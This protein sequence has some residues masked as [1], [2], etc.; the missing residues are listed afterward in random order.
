MA[1]GDEWGS[2]GEL[3]FGGGAPVWAVAAPGAT[4]VA[5][6]PELDSGEDEVARLRVAVALLIP[7]ARLLV[8]ADPAGLILVRSIRHGRGVPQ[9]PGTSQQRVGS[10]EEVAEPHVTEL[11]P[12]LPEVISPAGVV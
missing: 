5:P 6:V 7:G 8:D 2:S 9:L 3:P 10:A 11:G 4:T 12:P 1:A